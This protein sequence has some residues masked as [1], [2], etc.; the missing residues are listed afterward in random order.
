MRGLRRRRIWTVSPLFYLM[1]A[2][3]LVMA[4]VTYRY[5]KIAFAVEMTVSSLVASTVARTFS[6]PW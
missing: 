4:L 6:V 3:M 2:A 5:N 1:A